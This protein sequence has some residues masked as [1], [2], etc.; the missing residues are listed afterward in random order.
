M[1][2][3]LRRF[4]ARLCAGAPFVQDRAA[5][6]ELSVE[7]GPV[8][9][10]LSFALEQEGVREARVP[11]RSHEGLAMLTLLGRRAGI[12]GLTP[13]A[14]L[15]L[16]PALGEALDEAGHDV[17][18]A[19]TTTL[20]MVSMEGYVAGREERLLAESVDR[21]AGALGYVE[22]SPGCMALLLAGLHDPQSLRLVGDDFSR[23][24]LRRDVRACVV[25]IARLQ[26]PSA[27]RAAELLAV[28]HTAATLGV[29][30]WVAGDRERWAHVLS[31]ARLDAAEAQWAASFKD[32]LPR[33][34]SAAGWHL[35][36]ERH[37]PL[38]RSPRTSRS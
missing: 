1:E 18:E 14:A 15:S 34:L 7:A 21:A 9:E 20:Q 6:Q 25:D 3:M 5:A 4:R 27:E 11:L 16:A 23:Q 30:S 17:T 19:V 24:L 37:W 38:G 28:V 12:V 36:R 35:R 22:L 13:T 10:A 2:S 29:R 33:A 32:A 31:D 26:E 8:L